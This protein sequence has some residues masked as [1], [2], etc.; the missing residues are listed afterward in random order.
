MKNIGMVLDRLKFSLY[1]MFAV[2]LL[3]SVYLVNLLLHSAAELN[4]VS[5]ENSRTVFNSVISKE[6]E[7][8]GKLT[9]DYAYWNDAVEKTG[10][11]LDAD[12]IQD[13]Y[14]GSYMADSFAVKYVAI[15][16]Q[17][18]QVKMLI[19][20]G[21]IITDSPPAFAQS[22]IRHLVQSALNT[23]LTDPQPATG[24]IK[25]GS[26]IQIVAAVPIT[27]HDA[28]NS[29]LDFGKAYGVLLMT[30]S[31]DKPLLDDW[32]EDYRL[33]SAALTTATDVSEHFLQIVLLNPLE[34]RLA[35]I[36]WQAQQPGA[37]FASR[38]L[39]WLMLVVVTMLVIVTFFLLSI[40]KYIGMSMQMATELE[41]SQQE[42]STLAYHDQITGLPNRLLAMD[43][44]SQAIKHTQRSDTLAAVMFIDL[45]G[46]KPVN[47]KFG[48][49]FGDHALKEVG[50][51]LQAC[52]RQLDTVARM[53][54]D[55]F[56]IV[57]AE[58]SAE[59]DVA[60]IAEKVLQALRDD[61]YYQ[62]ARLNISAS[63]GIAIA[64]RDGTD[65]EQL[66]IQ[67]DKA[68]YCSKKNGKD[69]YHFFQPQYQGTA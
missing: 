45:D 1:L 42:L 48:H 41:Q 69:C 61:I 28:Q 65:P 58:L 31:L 39:P 49:M 15:L 27:P 38:N 32:S 54:G 51:R 67:A 9:K 12:F 16:S 59:G 56:L 52:V 6:K 20:D 43:R 2:L 29:G 7:N 36:T 57:L 46:F 11:T 26:D 5:A 64:P 22:A 50:R 55:E 66:I 40:R 34:Q 68:M 4:A 8:L 44:L 17:A 18:G 60:G 53:G 10:L 37:L 35:T 13:N 62:H 24:F 3:M 33:Q 14:L 47:D 30:K 23:D 21:E 63:I 25:I 19:R